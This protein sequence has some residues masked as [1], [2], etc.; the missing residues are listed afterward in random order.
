LLVLDHEDE[1]CSVNDV[2]EFLRLVEEKTGQRP[3]L[4]SGYVIKEQLGDR[5]DS[6]LASTRLWLA[7]YGSEAEAPRCWPAGPWLWQYT[8]GDMGPTP[9]TVDGIGKCDINSY[10]GSKQE[11]IASWAPAGIAPPQPEPPPRPPMP[12][13]VPPWLMVMRAI[14][15]MTEA[16]GSANNPH[17]LHMADAIGREWPAQANYAAQYTSDDI[18]WCGLTVAYCVST[19]GY[20]PQYGATDTERWMWAQ[21]WDEWGEELEEPKQ[22]CIV[23]QVRDGG[24]HVTLFEHWDGGMLVCRG[25]NQSDMVKLSSYDPGVVLSYRWPRK[26]A[27][28]SVDDLEPHELQLVQAALNVTIAP[29][30]LLDVDGEYGPKTE[31]AIKAFQGQVEI[32][33]SGIPTKGTVD[34]LL[35]A[36][37]DWNANRKSLASGG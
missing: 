18:A 5:I 2:K 32:T 17:I 4:Y 3:A 37:K 21:S 14:T 27:H 20:E 36:C 6:Y 8:D 30:P 15:G 35:N 26:T 9:H 12:D 25:G 11:L 22:G 16:P 1:G 29:M 10:D 13:T 33:E 28:V 7:Q 23:V 34:E 19:A 24:G 31:D